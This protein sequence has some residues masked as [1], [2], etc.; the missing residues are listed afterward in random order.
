MGT[1]PHRAGV[2]R[3]PS[4][5]SRP[6]ARRR[7]TGGRPA[8]IRDFL[9]SGARAFET[10]DR[11]GAAE[12]RRSPSLPHR[13]ADPGGIR[14]LYELAPD[15]PLVGLAFGFRSV[16]LADFGLGVERVA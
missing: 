10:G 11:D 1:A 12:G 6:P 2:D 3:P 9:S 14:G 13:F 16:R 5:A 15:D 7:K 4:R 8:S